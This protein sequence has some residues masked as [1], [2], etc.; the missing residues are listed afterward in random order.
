MFEIWKEIILQKNIIAEKVFLSHWDCEKS[1]MFCHFRKLE[2]FK[3]FIGYNIK[4]YI[5][6]S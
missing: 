1:S 5:E 3:I 2:N 4:S 6:T